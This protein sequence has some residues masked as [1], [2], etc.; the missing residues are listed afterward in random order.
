M[1]ELINSQLQEFLQV[2]IE[3]AQASGHVLRKYWGKISCI[4]EKSYAGDLVTEADQESEQLIMEI[5]H[6]RFPTHGFQGEEFG[7]QPIVNEDFNWVVD[8]LDGTTNYTHQFPFV[9]ISI[10]LLYRNEPILGVIYNPIFEE[11]FHGVK[12]NGAYLNNSKIQVSCVSNLSR[13]LLAT[14]FAYDRNETEDNNY[15]EFCHLTQAAQG[16]RR[17]GSAA[18]DLAYVAAGRLDGYWEKGLQPWDMVAGVA[19]VR[20]AG[21]RV[22]AYDLSPFALN[23]GRVLA[24]NG[25]IHE[26]LSIEL[27]KKG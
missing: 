25:V 21:G 10:G 11:L 15:S 16:V 4:K 19:I 3:A 23:S 1:T 5:L 6:T 12:G 2:A 27:K 13:S 7:I 17:L 20:E 14:G 24:T 26:Q 8:P 18:L 22:T 9:S